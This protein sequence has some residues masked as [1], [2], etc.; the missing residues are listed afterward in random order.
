MSGGG[1]NKRQ[2]TS[3]LYL[4]FEFGVVFTV[5]SSSSRKQ[6]SW[7]NFR[8]RHSSTDPRCLWSKTAALTG[9]AR[10]RKTQQAEKQRRSLQV[11][12]T[13]E[14]EAELAAGPLPP[15][16]LS[17]H[18][19]KQRCHYYHHHYLPHRMDDQVHCSLILTSS[20]FIVKPKW[21]NRDHALY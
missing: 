21:S 3:N 16:S 15:L 9:G 19:I 4:H 18:S 2:R 20:L 6:S 14:S 8:H 17:V 7:R 12:M 1:S 13:D 10:P 11:N 5:A